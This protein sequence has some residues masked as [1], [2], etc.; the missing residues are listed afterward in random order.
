MIAAR[1]DNGLAGSGSTKNPG[2]MVPGFIFVN[3]PVLMSSG[4]HTGSSKYPPDQNASI[5]GV[6]DSTSVE[7]EMVITGAV[8]S[9]ANS[10]SGTGTGSDG[11]TTAPP[12][13]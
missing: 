7:L 10:G 3:E 2:T 4:F 1:H 12:P 5:S 11:L 13:A 9:L 8:D 6:P